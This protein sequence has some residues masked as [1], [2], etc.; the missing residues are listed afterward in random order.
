MITAIDRITPI[1]RESD[2]AGVATAAYDDMIAA[3]TA[4]T[5]AQWSAQTE[6]PGWTVSDMVGHLIGA[7]EAAASPRVLIGQ[8]LH[9]LRHAREFDGNAMD[10]YNALQVAE[11]AA[12]T[13]DERVAALRTLA[14]RAVR[15]RM[16]YPAL[17]RAVTMAVKIN[18]SYSQG[19]PTAISLSELLDVI[20]T[21]DVFMH[22]IDIT[23]ATGRPLEPSDNDRRIVQDVVVSW[24]RHHRQPVDLVLTGDAGGRFTQGSGGPRIE[25]DAYEFCRVLSGRV[26]GEGLLGAKV[27]F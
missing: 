22:R 21:R 3:L 10:A 11:H 4:L 7:A 25:L 12:L 1:T 27:I 13:P 26:P 17:L 15:T 18:G 19:M 24:A 14:P 23:R 5:P 2:A 8:N 9:G 6:C 16:R 20:W